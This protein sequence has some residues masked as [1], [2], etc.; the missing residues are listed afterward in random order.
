MIITILVFVH[1]IAIT[2]NIGTAFLKSHHIRI[3]EHYH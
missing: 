3:H 2:L 1:Y